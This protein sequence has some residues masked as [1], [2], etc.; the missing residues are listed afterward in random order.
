MLRHVSPRL[1]VLAVLVACAGRTSAAESALLNG[2][3]HDAWRP[4]SSDFAADVGTGTGGGSTREA[5]ADDPLFCFVVRTYWGHGDRYGG[6][7]RHLLRSLQRQR[8]QRYGLQRSLTC[9]C[10]RPRRALSLQVQ[11]LMSQCRW[12]AVLIVADNRPF[13]DLHHILRDMND[14]R[15]WV[16]AE[17][18]SAS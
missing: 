11:P 15:A 17:W 6:G 2:N 4:Q 1:A 18:V 14:T 12:E 16:F 5:A 7:L 8:H 3:P 9:P 10:P 13:P